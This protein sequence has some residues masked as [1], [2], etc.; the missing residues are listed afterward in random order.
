MTTI[1][2]MRPESSLAESVRL[3]EE[4]G[5]SVLS[6]PMMALEPLVDTRFERVL[7][8]LQSECIDCIVFTSSNGVSHALKLVEGSIGR[9]EFLKRL[10]CTKVA[11]IGA[12]TK[13]SLESLGVRVDH[14]PRTYSS[15]GLVELF[16]ELGV[17]G[18]RIVILR[19]THG[20]DQL[21]SGLV[22]LGALVDD[23]PVYTI[24]MP[25]DVESAK[26][27]VK[28]AARGDIDV[29]CFTSTMMV[30]NFLEIARSLGLADEVIAR[31]NGAKVAA[32]GRPTVRALESYGID[33]GIVPEEQTIEALLDEVVSKT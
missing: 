5:L 27:L 12:K 9:G 20:S 3:A 7:H 1:A 31:M 13:R 18:M 21:V 14:V 25:G 29:F 23:V 24:K 28:R 10:A 32:I 6:A 26:R 22:G 17:K 11:A 2:L 16:A 19:S 15:E 33:V 8:D 4:R 30:N